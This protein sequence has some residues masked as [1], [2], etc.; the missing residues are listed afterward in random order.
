MT[1]NTGLRGRGWHASENMAELCVW[2]QLTS[3][4]MINITNAYAGARLSMD[5]PLPSRTGNA[6]SRTP[7][8]GSPVAMLI[9]TKPKNINTPAISHPEDFCQCARLIEIHNVALRGSP[10]RPRLNFV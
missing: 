7:T 3:V 5:P 2:G 8:S 1:Y 10:V 6:L 9:C 4:P